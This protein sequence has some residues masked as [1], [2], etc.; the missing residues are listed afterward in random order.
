LKF[1]GNLVLYHPAW[2]QMEFVRGECCVV[3]DL[4]LIMASRSEGIVSRNSFVGL[5][6]FFLSHFI[7]Y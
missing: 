5:L 1:S 6:Y 7:T 3:G 2:Q 4:L